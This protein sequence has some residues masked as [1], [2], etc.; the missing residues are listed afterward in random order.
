LFGIRRSKSGDEL[1]GGSVDRFWL[2]P[3]RSHEYLEQLVWRFFGSFHLH[4]DVKLVVLAENCNRL[5]FLE[6]PNSATSV[7]G[8]SKSGPEPS[9]RDNG[10]S[11]F[12]RRRIGK[13]IPPNASNEWHNSQ[14][15]TTDVR[16]S[17]GFDCDWGLDGAKACWISQRVSGVVCRRAVIVLDSI[18][19]FEWARKAF[20]YCSGGVTESLDC[21]PVAEFHFDDNFD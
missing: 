14:S 3:D 16:R 21:G 17:H 9:L 12:G 4:G 8:W 6:R 11:E 5:F 2:K 10:Q 1:R 15:G 13:R 19:W 20:R 18:Q 7:H